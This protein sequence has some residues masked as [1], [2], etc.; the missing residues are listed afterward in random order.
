MKHYGLLGFPLKHTMSPPIHQRLFELEGVSDFDYTLKEYSP[1]ELEGKISDVLALDGFNITIPHKVE[2]IKYIDELADSAKRYNS[3]NCVAHKDGKYIGYNT[4]C[5]GFLRSLEAAGAG[6]DGKVLQCGCGGVGRMIA[7]EAVRH[8]AELTV[9]VPEGFED[10]VEPVKEYAI[11]NGFSDDIKVVHPSEI[12]GKFDLLINASPVGMFPKVE[13]CPVSED[14]IKNCGFVF[15]VI[16]N[17]ERTK[18][19]QTAENFGIKTCGGMAMLVWQAVVAHEIWSGAK[20]NDSDI[21]KL[22]ADMHKLMA[23]KE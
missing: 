7:I 14:V 20:Y 19:M 21:A 18:L 13:N 1:E 17:P 23:E 15:D 9:S 12:S 8:G 11:A 6:L 10:T 4:D 22:I 5:D 2:I 3:V 16:Y